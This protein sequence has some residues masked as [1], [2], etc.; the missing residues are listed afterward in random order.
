MR[1]LRLATFDTAVISRVVAAGGDAFT[2]LFSLRT[3]V[4]F[5]LG[6]AVVLLACLAVGGIAG[7]GGA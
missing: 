6:C 1:A 7:P 4:A 5:C 2:D 3:P